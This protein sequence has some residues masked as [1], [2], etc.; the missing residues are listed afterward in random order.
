MLGL[1][2]VYLVGKRGY[3]LAEK[4][5]RSAWGFAILAVVVYYA[6]SFLGGILI[7]VVDAFFDTGLLDLPDIVIGIFAIPFGLAA[8]WGFLRLLE[9][10]W[11]KPSETSNDIDDLVDNFGTKQQESEFE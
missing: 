1:L 10:S 5:K 3:N 2:L 9:K 8:W 11:S 7:G 4:Y 6:G